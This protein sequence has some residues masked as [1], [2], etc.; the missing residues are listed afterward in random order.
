M[1]IIMKGHLLTITILCWGATFVSTKVLLTDFTPIEIL[2]TRFSI[3]L[4]ILYIIR[5]QKLKL[6]HEVH[7]KYLV[8]AALA[9]I[10]LYYLMENLALTDTYASN[11][12]IISSTAPLFA[13]I[14]ASFVLRKHLFKWPI[15]YWVYS[16]YYRNYIYCIRRKS[17]KY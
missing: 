1:G 2:I 8:V 5:P 9:G 4:T 13:A 12:G 14:L 10:T 7:R 6:R 15:L 3:G 11:V 16:S 17:F